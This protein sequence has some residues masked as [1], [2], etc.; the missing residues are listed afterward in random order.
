MKRDL[1]KISLGQ[2]HA[3]SDRELR[4]SI[5]TIYTIVGVASDRINN[6]RSESANRFFNFKANSPLGIFEQQDLTAKDQFETFAA[7]LVRGFTLTAK[8]FGSMNSSKYNICSVHG[9]FFD[10]GQ[11][12][13]LSDPIP[14]KKEV[15][16]N[17]DLIPL[18]VLNYPVGKRHE[19]DFSAYDR[20]EPG[21]QSIKE[22]HPMLVP[23]LDSSFEIL[24]REQAWDILR[25][26]I[27]WR[28][29]LERYD[30]AHA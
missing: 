2:K 9:I 3:L 19:I 27:P 24:T 8:S 30:E 29:T 18:S 25:I 1:E 11:L 28:T 5:A 12:R 4:E 7:G 17:P 20:L 15:I 26:H 13:E 23:L 10:G 14:C 22:S 16:P 21:R 6:L